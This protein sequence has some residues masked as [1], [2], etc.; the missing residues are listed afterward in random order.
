MFSKSGKFELG[1]GFGPSFFLGDLGGN[2]GKGAAFIKDINVK[3][4]QIDKRVY[5][6]WYPSE[7]VGVRLGANYTVVMAD[8]AQIKNFG[9]AEEDRRFRNLSF[10]S[11]VAEGYVAAELYP[12]T[13]LDR[14]EGLAGKFKPYVVAG[15][16]FF[17]FNPKAKANNGEW[18]YLHPL[19]LEGQGF[20][21]YPNSKPYSLIQMEIPLGFGFKYFL[22]D[23]FY[24]G[25]E[26]LYRKTFTDYVDDV[27]TG[28]INPAIFDNHLSANDA[29]LA[30]Q[31]YYRGTYPA[32][33][34]NP[35]TLQ[36]GYIRG[37]PKNNDAFFSFIVRFG[38]RLNGRQTTWYK[39]KHQNRCPNKI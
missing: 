24:A 35:S 3:L 25:T 19:R 32:V 8:D 23:N 4:T 16:G 10:K 1:L 28:Y 30:K 31:L 17:K 22:N 21:E 37:N 26:M 33:L 34:A 18:I 20:S 9:D 36:S 11:S 6:V 39:I 15:I 29:L 38:F 5:L 13:F 12:F 2:Q 27:S 7:W 14:K